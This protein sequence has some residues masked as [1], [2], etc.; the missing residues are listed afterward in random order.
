MQSVLQNDLDNLL[1]FAYNQLPKKQHRD[2]YKECLELAII[3]L[4]GTVTNFSKRPGAMH[5]PRWMAKILY[6]LKIRMCRKQMN[7]LY[8]NDIELVKIVSIL[9]VQCTSLRE[10]HG[11]Q[12]VIHHPPPGQI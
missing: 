11:S 6:C 8:Q 3:F 9:A 7:D 12:L 5:C 2:D 4:G 10:S 1:Q